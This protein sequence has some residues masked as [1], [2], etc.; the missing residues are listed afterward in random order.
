[1]DSKETRK[2]ASDDLR[3]LFEQTIGD[4]GNMGFIKAIRLKSLTFKYADVVT[5]EL[6]VAKITPGDV[7]DKSEVL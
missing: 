2:A 5:D 7:V 4:L 3:G 6:G 1:M